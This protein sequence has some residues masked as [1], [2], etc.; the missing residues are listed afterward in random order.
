MCEGEES[1][2]PG[3]CPKC[4]MAL[5][6][7]PAHLRSPVYTCP[8]HPEVRT[9]RPGDCPKCGMALE[10][11]DNPDGDDVELRDMT[12]RLWIGIVLTVP[13]LF[14]AMGG[15]FVEIVPAAVSVWVQLALST[16]VVVWCG[17]PFLE[18]GA[19]SLVSRHLNMFTL[20]ALGT[21]AAYL[22]SLVVTMFP[23]L[24]PH[25]LRHGGML[26]VYFEAAA[27]IVVL[28][29]AGQVLELRARA[30]TGE[31]IR[32]LLG[33]APPTAHRVA[34]DA[35][36]DV[37]VAVVQPG[38]LLRVKPGEKIPVDGEITEGRSSV[39][40]SMLTGEPVPVGKSAGSPVSAGTLNG[41]GTF[42]F[43]ASKVG[44]DTLLAQIVGL[45]S[46]AQRSRAPIQR[47][48]DSVAAW[49]VPAVIGIAAIAFAVWLVAGQSAPFAL[50]AAISVLIIACPCALGLAT[51]MSVMVGVGR[52]AGMGVLFKD[53]EALEVL[54]T[55]T[56]V[57]ADKTGTLTEG[58]PSVVD[59]VTSMD[60]SALLNI[61]AALEV[62]SEHPL[63]A[64]V[65]RAAG[66]ISPVTDFASFP[67]GGVRGNVDGR[68]VLVGNRALLA[69]RGIT[70]MEPYDADARRM[71]SVGNTVIWTAVDGHAAGLIALADAVKASTPA[72]ISALH[73]MGLTLMML[74]GDSQVTAA[75]VARQLGIDTVAAGVT[76][77]GKQHYVAGLMK[78]GE[79]VAM[80][81][82]GV[83]DAPALAAAHVGI[84]MGAGS[85][86]A[87]HT[88]G[89]TLVK[90]DLRSIV[91]AIA[92]SRATMRNIRQNLLFAFLYNALGIP[93]AAGVL[94][95]VLG[96][97]LSP[98][99]ASA[100][101]ALSSVSVITNALR[102]R[103][104]P[105]GRDR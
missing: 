5:E 39:D 49:F 68:P 59:V 103:S 32:A 34:I 15:H 51:P 35:D 44:K 46:S 8:M 53:A 41:A 74:T 10:A 76:P 4:G 14:L 92:L 38:D 18:R 47:L 26:P 84:A 91:D 56:V 23:G 66:S 40:E 29:L 67:G 28:V 81:G 105:L 9:N 31:A 78:A 79:I 75:H 62:R 13:L 63:G 83:N 43:R 17:W 96:L 102:L 22:F 71:E 37:A 72:A 50:V 25:G 36:E 6:R 104:V 20:I 60:R 88:A 101:M 94:Y 70:G 64:A 30:G 27:A 95:P 7:N 99:V 69:D 58:R 85:D 55:V 42:L 48:A 1:D 80:A 54:G 87:L 97:L 19:R 12:R 2:R 24:L 89:V 16:P 57:V 86:V 21:G 33:L 65:A 100:A 98:I 82:D 73:Q 77:A 45:V 11:I 90:G 93:L 52:G 61:A 3:A